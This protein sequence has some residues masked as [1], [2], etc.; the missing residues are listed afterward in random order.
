VTDLSFI[1]IISRIERTSALLHNRRLLEKSLAVIMALQEEDGGILATP[2]DDVYPYVYP[3]DA[4]IMTAAMNTHGE[5]ERSKKFYAFLNRVRR[6]HGEFYQ[7]YNGGMPY[8]SNEH[9]LDVTPLVLDGIYD[10]YT[11]SGDRLFLE[12]MWGLVKECA[13]FTETAIDNHVGLVYTAN[14]IHENRKLEEGFEIW[15][16]SASVK[17]LLDASRMAAA[18]GHDD[19]RDA[20]ESSS[21]R[22]LARVVETLYDKEERTFIKVMRRSGEKVSAPDMSQLAP[23]YFGIYRDD[24]ALAETLEGL[25]EA[26][27]NKSIGGFNRFR[28]FEVVDD[29]HWYTGG[30][31]A[32]WPFLTLWAARSYRDLGIR[33]GE[34]SCLAFLDSVLT[35]DLLIA[36][37]VAPMEGYR[38]W[39]ANELKFAHRAMNGVRKVESNVH[40]IG[41]KGYVCWACPL[42]WAHAEYILYEMQERS[43]DYEFLQEGI[44]SFVKK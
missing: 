29:W 2:L 30:T 6:P 39:K 11:K 16:N 1:W 38:E 10:T 28:D 27:W 20:W 15:A 35:D 8:V 23:Y 4:A 43:R 12:E 25:K 5:Y 22:L 24:A 32:A 18:L 41:A 34:D 33:E 40:R 44:Q 19:L 9:E 37:K 14:S 31:G 26:L 36:E 21:R 17:G 7:R 42:G 3:R 13:S